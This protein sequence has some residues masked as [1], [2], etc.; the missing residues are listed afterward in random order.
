[1]S[2][3]AG[4]CACVCMYV[5]AFECVW[6]WVGGCTCGRPRREYVWE[7]G[8][9]G[10]F[11]IGWVGCWLVVGAC[12]FVRIFFARG[13]WC[14]FYFVC[15]CR[16]YMC[17]ACKRVC[18]CGSTVREGACACVFAYAYVCLNVCVYVCVRVRVHPPSPS[19]F[20]PFCFGGFSSYEDILCFTTRCGLFRE[21]I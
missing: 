3:C 13:N 18:V 1:M 14:V 7:C 16:V 20:T 2:T 11:L 8:W 12:V 17:A 4:V 6:V 9:V 15:V 10:G 21:Q 19:K 5:C